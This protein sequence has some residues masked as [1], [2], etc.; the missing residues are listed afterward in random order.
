MLV[1][2]VYQF[3]TEYH[4]FP[5]PQ[6]TA[7]AAAAS[8]E[9]KAVA[10]CRGRTKHVDP[11]RCMHVAFKIQTHICFT[12]ESISIYIYF[13]SIHMI[14]HACIL[15][16]KVKLGPLQLVPKTNQISFATGTVVD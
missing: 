13:I 12:L 5:I 4:G 2:P 6:E 11:P 16:V 15:S 7:P 3:H 1:K 10:S 14:S 9:A 8:D